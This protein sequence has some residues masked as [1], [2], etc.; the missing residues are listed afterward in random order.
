VAGTV[1]LYAYDANSNVSSSRYNLSTFQTGYWNELTLA[2]PAS[3]NWSTIKAMGLQIAP[4]TPSNTCQNGT[5][6][7]DSVQL[8]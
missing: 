8:K 7:I 3:V 5:V 4:G 2:L 6:Y 1:Q